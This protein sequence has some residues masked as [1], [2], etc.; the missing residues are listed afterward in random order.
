M[1]LAGVSEQAGVI[2]QSRAEPPAKLQALAITPGSAHLA[3]WCA[4][5]LRP[6]YVAEDENR[7]EVAATAVT[8]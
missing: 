1:N 7:V 5:R 4:F 2:K 6:S 3:H 8:L